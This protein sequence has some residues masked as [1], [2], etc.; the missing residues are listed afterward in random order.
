MSDFCPLPQPTFYARKSAKARSISSGTSPAFPACKTYKG[1]SCDPDAGI[2][3]SGH[4]MCAC[5]GKSQVLS[6]LISRVIAHASCLLCIHLWRGNA[7]HKH[8]GK[9]RGNKLR[10]EDGLLGTPREEVPNVAC[11]GS[12]QPGAHCVCGHPWRALL[13]ESAQPGEDAWTHTRR[14]R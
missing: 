14:V 10:R 6:V 5:Q 2:G 11:C 1:S 13:D 9:A 7:V 12:A 4:E 8:E 3:N